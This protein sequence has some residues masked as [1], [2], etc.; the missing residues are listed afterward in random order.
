MNVHEWLQ[1]KYSKLDVRFDT[2]H[3][4]LEFALPEPYIVET[5]CV[6]LEDDWGGGMS[7]LVFSNFVADF[8]GRVTSIDIS[9]E[10]TELCAK[11]CKEYDEHLELIVSDSVKQL[12]SIPKD[13]TIDLLYLDSYDYP[14]GE[15]LEIYGG[16]TDIH[17]AVDI[18]ADMSDDEIVE[19]H[20]DV[21][22][23]S[24]EHCLKELK[25]ALPNLLDE[26][27]ILIDDSDLPGGGKA[28]LAKLFLAELGYTCLLDSYQTLWVKETK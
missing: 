17:K 28:R 13:T 14:Y 4:A 19:K 22:N 10:N 8:G 3:K 20:F 7:T 16:K 9:K 25:A 12:S 21:I 11:V 24:Q 5:G 1:K 26:T 6:R 27:P 23:P 2:M 18:V 15:L